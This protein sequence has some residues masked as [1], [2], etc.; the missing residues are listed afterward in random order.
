MNMSETVGQERTRDEQQRRFSQE[1]YE[2]L[3]RCSD[4]EDMSEWNEWRAKNRD[5]DVELESANFCG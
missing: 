1:Q 5:R 4:K 2:M 3:K